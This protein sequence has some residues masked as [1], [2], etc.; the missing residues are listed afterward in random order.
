MPGEDLTHGPPATKKQAA[1]TTGSVGSTDI[2]CAMVLTA[3]VVRAPA[4]PAFVSPSLAESRPAGLTPATR[5]SGPH[6][7]A[8]RINAARRATSTRPSHP[9]LHVW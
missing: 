1:V 3:Y 9:A 6:A 4:R 8:V 5:A 2:P 7:F